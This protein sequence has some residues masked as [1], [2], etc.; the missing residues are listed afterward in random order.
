MKQA[1][2]AKSLNFKANDVSN[3]CTR[4]DVENA[5][6]VVPSPVKQI[7]NVHHKPHNPRIVDLDESLNSN[8]PV[9]SES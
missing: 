3:V 2:Y 9:V 5:R 1:E 4:A 8:L 6:H 7:S